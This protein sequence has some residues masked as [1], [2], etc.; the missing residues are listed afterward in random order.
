MAVRG[1]FAG[2]A[3]AF[4]LD[5]KHGCTRATELLSLPTPGCLYRC[6]AP[7]DCKAGR[8]PDTV[9]VGCE[10]Y[11]LQGPTRFWPGSGEQS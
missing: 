6:I 5:T 11:C 9:M 2:M 4:L 8:A 7:A 3:E 10:V 1:R